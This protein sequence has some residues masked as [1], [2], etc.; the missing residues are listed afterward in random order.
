MKILSEEIYPKSGLIPIGKLAKKTR[1][2]V[3]TIRYYENLKLLPDPRTRNS[4]KNRK[5]SNSYILRLIFI[6]KA[7]ELG[8]SLKEIKGMIRL[9]DRKKK[10]PRKKLIQKVT[11]KMDFIEDQ[12]KE[13]KSLKREL[14]SLV[15]DVSTP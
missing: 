4:P 6:R 15:T 7:R 3:V 11:E 13:L 8:F 14:R 1:T 2:T 10:I 9:S 5:Y 12:I